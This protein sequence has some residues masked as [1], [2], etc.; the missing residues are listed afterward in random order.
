MTE[1]RFNYEP[2]NKVFIDCDNQSHSITL[3]NKGKAKEF[4]NY[5]RGIIQND[6][7]YLRVYYPFADISE[8]SYNELIKKSSILLNEYK[9]DILKA[10]KKHYSL[11]PKDV[12]LNVTNDS[13]KGHLNTLYV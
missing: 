6:I 8:L 9:A 3:H 11:K 4:D 10:V 12:I 13:L 2:F 7:V 1:K 5:I